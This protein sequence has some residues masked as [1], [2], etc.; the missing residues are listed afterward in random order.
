M[1]H[2]LFSS[3][4]SNPL[5]LF[6]RDVLRIPKKSSRLNRSNLDPF[7]SLNCYQFFVHFPLSPSSLSLPPLSIYLPIY[8]SLYLS[9]YLNIYVSLFQE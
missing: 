5:Y 2:C 1:N 7:Y 9:I 3:M 4:S 8:L 6:F